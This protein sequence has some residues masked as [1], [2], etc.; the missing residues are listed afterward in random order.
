MM[1]IRPVV[2]SE[3]MAGQDGVRLRAIDV[4]AAAAVAHTQD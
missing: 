1:L 4:V 3:D 2:G